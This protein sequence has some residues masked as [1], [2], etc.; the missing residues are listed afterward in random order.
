VDEETK[1]ALQFLTAPGTEDHLSMSVLRQSLEELSAWGDPGSPT[2]LAMKAED[3]IIVREDRSHLKLRSYQPLNKSI[4]QAILFFHGGGFIAGSI[5]SHD[6]FCRRLA[7][8]SNCTVWSVQY[9]LAP[10]HPFPA[11]LDDGL[12]AFKSLQK[13]PHVSSLILAGDSAGGNLCISLALKLQQMNQS[14][15]G[16]IAFYPC[17]DLTMGMPS[18]QILG[19]GYFLEAAH[20]REFF[21]AYL[22]SEPDKSNPLVSPAFQPDLRGFPP[23]FLCVCGFDPLR[24]EGLLFAAR[25][26]EADVEVSLHYESQTIHGVASLAGQI[27]IGR[28]LFSKA[29]QWVT[30]FSM[31]GKPNP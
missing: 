28:H 20:M 18:H 26:R 8:Q 16:I 7:S 25:L 14:A 29:G 31:L 5:S 22:G 24:D 4:H 30:D 11:A 19:Q 21:K 27:S 23:T 10:E 3:F 1:S 13:E 15:D 9:R 6:M 17:L 2:L 12:L